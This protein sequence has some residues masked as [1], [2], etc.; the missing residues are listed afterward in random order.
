MRR[1]PQAWPRHVT[2]ATG[3]EPGGGC[4]AHSTPLA[5]G[6]HAAA[7]ATPCCPTRRRTSHIA[8]A[9]ADSMAAHRSSSSEVPLALTVIRPVN[10]RSPCPATSSAS[11]RSVRVT[12]LTGLATDLGLGLARLLQRT[13]SRRAHDDE[14]RANLLRAG[15]ILAFVLGSVVG[16]WLFSH[17]GYHGFALPGAIAAYAAVKGRLEARGA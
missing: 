11:R 7:C 15:S 17:A 4:A 13:A 8:C 3:T 6:R 12:H 10:R 9:A 16:A 5:N 1:Q 14:S 2:T